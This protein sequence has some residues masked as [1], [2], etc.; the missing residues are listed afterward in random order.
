MISFFQERQKM[1][2]GWFICSTLLGLTAMSSDPVLASPILVFECQIFFK[3]APSPTNSLF[4]RYTIR[5]H[6]VEREPTDEFVTE[7]WSQ[8]RFANDGSFEVDV[9]PTSGGVETERATS[10][11]TFILDG[12]IDVRDEIIDEGLETEEN[13]TFEELK[14]DNFNMI[15]TQ[16]EGTVLTSHLDYPE[17]FDLADYDQ[18]E[19]IIYW[20]APAPVPCGTGGVFCTIGSHRGTITSATLEAHKEDHGNDFLINAGLNDAWVNADAPF[21]G[22]FITVY[23]DLGLIFVA[24]FT[25][26]SSIPAVPPD[27]AFGAPDQ[28]WITAVGVFAGNKATLKAELT[29]GGRFHSSDPLP[30]QDTEYGT[31][32][33]EFKDCREATVKFDFPSAME[34]GEF[35]ITRALEENAILCDALGSG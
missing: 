12:K 11:R 31:I 10:I 5:R 29:S 8:G 1:R 13:L 15:F 21:Q 25:F 16:N 20:R 28:R 2:P 17:S 9:Y 33:L 32:E 7:A 23:A 6:V 34:S 30:V 22:M 18:K 24:W 3:Q 27:A 26:D 14:L 4:P 35:I 19:C